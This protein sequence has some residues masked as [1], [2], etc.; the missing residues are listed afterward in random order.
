[1]EE[2]EEEEEEVQEEEEEEEEKE[3]VYERGRTKLRA[4]EV[5][6]HTLLCGRSEQNIRE[7]GTAVSKGLPG[8]KEVERVRGRRTEGGIE[9]G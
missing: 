4:G 3:E 1:M 6:A 8:L 2:K 7:V 5:W 9:G